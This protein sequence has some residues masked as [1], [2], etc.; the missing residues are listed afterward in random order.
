MFG[1]L[2]KQ[3]ASQIA[4]KLESCCMDQLSKNSGG[5]TES[6]TETLGKVHGHRRALFVGINYFG[7]K[8][9]L[10][11]CIN[12][13]KNIKDFLTRNYDIDEYLVLTDDSKDPKCQPTR[14]NI[15]NAFK[16]LRQGAKPGESLIFH[17]SG[18]GGSQKDQD[19]DEEDGM[20][21]TLC[22]VD[23]A[24]AGVIVDDEVHEILCRG[25]PKGVRLTSISKCV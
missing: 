3:Y 25:L 4:G 22:P 2:G 17:Y 12:D 16:W 9:E 11:G 7:T 8:S 15:I 23:Y 13:V 6:A 14:A 10:R 24:T 18:H 20:D 21:E 19:G 5:A 1:N